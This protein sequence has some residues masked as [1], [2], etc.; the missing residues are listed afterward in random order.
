M[1]QQEIIALA[2]STLCGWFIPAVVDLI[3]K[4]NL[5]SKIKASIAAVLAAIAGAF[6]TV[7]FAPGE[8]WYNYL[9]AVGWAFFSTMSA[10]QT[11]YSGI[12]QELT[13]NFGFGK[14]RQTEPQQE[15][16]TGHPSDEVVS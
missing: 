11:Q 4:S 15:E 16:P 12:I 7:T 5:N 8:S 10:H 6:T 14:K 3:T 13:S 9:V 2:V 1:S